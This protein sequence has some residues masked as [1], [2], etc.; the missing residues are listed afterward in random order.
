EPAAAADRAGI[1]RSRGVKSPQPARRLSSLFGHRRRP[2]RRVPSRL[3]Q[4]RWAMF[5]RRSAR[6]L[7]VCLAGKP[8]PCS[9]TEGVLMLRKTILL[10]MGAAG[11]AFALL[12]VLA[13]AGLADPRLAAAAFGVAVLAA[14]AD[15]ILGALVAGWVPRGRWRPPPGGRR[16]ARVGRL[17]S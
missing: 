1:G 13:A 2:A 15:E 12:A 6:P 17:S 8:I 5:D 4:V 11:V 16:A 10:L 7:L 14:G 3:G 9:A